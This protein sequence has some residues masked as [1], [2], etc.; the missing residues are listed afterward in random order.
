MA[1]VLGG[2]DKYA[3]K[4]R[5]TYNCPNWVWENGTPCA[6]CVAKGWESDLAGLFDGEPLSEEIA[7]PT[8]KRGHIH[9]VIRNYDEKEGT[10]TGTWGE[11]TGGQRYLSA[12][13][14]FNHP[15]PEWED[16]QRRHREPIEELPRTQLV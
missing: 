3:C 11:P 15:G 10:G 13:G 5:L 7:V 9:Y 4:N 6:E 8:I 2:Y 16:D 14:L 12:Q 1:N